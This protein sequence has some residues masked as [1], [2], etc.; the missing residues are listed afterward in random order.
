VKG[1]VSAYDKNF[2]SWASTA[3]GWW[4]HFDAR[5]WST[6][7]FVWTGFDYRGEPTP[8]NWPCISSH[9]GILDLCGFPKDLFY[10]YRA[11]WSG[12]PVL[13]LFPH[14]N[15]AG[16]EGQEI[17]VWCFTN[18]DTLE[19]FVNG[20]TAGWQKVAKNSHAAWKVRYQPGV[21]EVRGSSG[22]KEMTA[23]R[24]TVGPPSKIVL[25]PDRTAITA[26]GEDVSVVTVS[27][28]D[29]ENRIVPTAMNDV[30]FKITGPGRLI[31][32]GNGDPSS[33]EADRAD[34]RRAFNG[35][36]MAL[37]QSTHEPGQIRIEATSPG[38]VAMATSI[39]TS[40]VPRQRL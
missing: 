24:E 37:V 20:T 12:E 35:L 39:A 19:L 2:P 1:Y 22:G 9:F 30:T 38:L 4:S 31:G 34:H 32:V 33:H 29:S 25:R 16:K 18:C 5:P 14:W 13:H 10:Y 3:E 17:E 28:A 7:G 23:K 27:I 40:G 11:W 15:W 8:Y 26:D 6:G 21:I 36:C